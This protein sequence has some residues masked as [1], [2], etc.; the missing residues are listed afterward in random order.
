MG[1]AIILEMLEYV[2]LP[3][4]PSFSFIPL[5]STNQSSPLLAPFCFST[6]VTYLYSFSLP[7]AASLMGSGLLVP[8]PFLTPLSFLLKWSFFSPLLISP[9]TGLSLRSV[10]KETLPVSIQSGPCY[11]IVL[12]ALCRVTSPLQPVPSIT[13]AGTLHRCSRKDDI[14][15]Y[16]I[17]TRSCQSAVRCSLYITVFWQ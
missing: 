7:P 5:K 1:I 14:S 10:Q 9:A 17:R 2:S 12:L 16:S 3:P 4:S 13:R 11:I 8:D 6:A 15:L